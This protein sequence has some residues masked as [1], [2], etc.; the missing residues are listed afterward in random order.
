MVDNDIDVILPVPTYVSPNISDNYKERHDPADWDYLMEYL[1]K[2]YKEEYIVASKM[3]S[4][5]L[6]S[7]CNMFIA[8]R[9]VLEEMCE[10]IFP[11][12]DAVVE[13]GGCKEDV[14]MNRYAGFISERLITLF[15]EVHGNRFKIVYADKTFLN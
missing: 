11:I 4:E 15:F 5:N 3:F 10:F 2:Y 12:I 8:K 13:H 6:Y 7:P 14:Y 9:E 1:E